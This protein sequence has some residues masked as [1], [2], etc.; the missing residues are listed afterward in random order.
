MPNSCPCPCFDVD[1]VLGINASYQLLGEYIYIY[2]HV[3]IESGYVGM[4]SRKAN[5]IK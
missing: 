3:H 2:A 1:N 4:Q 5:R